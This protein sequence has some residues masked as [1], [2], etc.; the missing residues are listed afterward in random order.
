MNVRTVETEI[1]VL[2]MNRGGRGWLSGSGC[3]FRHHF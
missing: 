1:M 2:L 3:V